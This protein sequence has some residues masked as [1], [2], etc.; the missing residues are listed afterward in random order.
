MFGENRGGISSFSNFSGGL[1]GFANAGIG[2]GVEI[3]SN[4]LHYF[5]PIGKKN[6]EEIDVVTSSQDTLK[7]R[8]RSR[9]KGIDIY[10]LNRATL[11]L[12]SLNA[13]AND[14]LTSTKPSPFT[15]RLAHEQ[16][17]SKNIVITEDDP[18][19]ILLF[20]LMG[21]IRAVPYA[22]NNAKTVLGVSGHLYAS[23]YLKSWLF[24]INDATGELKDK[25]SLYVEPAIGFAIG[26][27]ALMENT[28][29]SSPSKP[30]VSVQ[31]Q[32]GYTSDKN[33]YKD[34]TA[35]IGY[36]FNKIVGPNLRISFTTT[37]E[38]D[39]GDPN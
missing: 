34:W 11:N 28:V 13:I 27:A 3:T 17:L 7:N 29:Y 38:T 23:L 30:L 20:R 19:P 21:D 39:R 16:F 4:S 37:I 1:G 22:N 32:L 15:F 8:P 35:F 14:Y 10:L 26:D 6:T 36:T 12:D 31:L 25:G 5:L 33:K 18:V 2:G 24:E 9:Y